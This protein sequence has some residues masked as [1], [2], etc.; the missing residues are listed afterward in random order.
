MSSVFRSNESGR[1]SSASSKATGAS[2]SERSER[3][4]YARARL[5]RHNCSC[6]PAWARQST[7]GNLTFRWF[8]IFPASA[9]IC[10]T[11][12]RAPWFLNA[13][14]PVSLASAES[15]PNLLRYMCFKNGP[16]TSN[17]AEAGA[18][19]KTSTHCQVPDLQY[20][21]GAGYFV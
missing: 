8:A 4:F 16:L 10:K 5:D 6:S 18:F 15:L 20:H 12:L 1:P 17:V 9:E 14:K 19:I 2:R 21:F 7:C 13:T 11:T 3:L